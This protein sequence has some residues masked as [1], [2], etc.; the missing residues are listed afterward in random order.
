MA[1]KSMIPN[2]RRNLLKRISPRKRRESQSQS[3]QLHQRLL[4]HQSHPLTI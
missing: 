2:K 1:K 3:V 4:E